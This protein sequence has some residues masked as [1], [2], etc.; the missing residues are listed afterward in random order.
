MQISVVICAYKRPEMLVGALRSL[1]GQSLPADQ[2]EVIVVDNNSGP[3]IPELVAEYARTSPH[4]L[5]YVLEP[6]QGISYARNAGV[7]AAKGDIVAF[8]DDDEVADEKWLTAHLDVYEQVPEVSAIVGK[9]LPLW[10]SEAPKWLTDW[11]LIQELNMIYWGEDVH[12]L[13]FRETLGTGNSSFRR[14]VFDEVGLFDPSRAVGEDIDMQRRMEAADK[15][16]YY[17]PHAVVYHHVKPERARKR[18]FYRTAFVRGKQ[19]ASAAGRRRFESLP[20][21]VKPQGNAAQRLVRRAFVPIGYLAE[22]GLSEQG[23]VFLIRHVF[24]IWGFMFETIRTRVF[25]RSEAQ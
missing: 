15:L 21:E 22:S 13:T 6:S 18:H 9:A 3:P 25:G 17:T 23:R 4:E 7:L 12:P 10:E 1:S 20:D 16:I 14:K 24:Y 19:R 2:F 5:R 8:L 11:R